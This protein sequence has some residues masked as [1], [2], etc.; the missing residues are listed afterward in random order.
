M[1][2]SGKKA[3]IRLLMCSVRERLHLSC[4]AEESCAVSKLARDAGLDEVTVDNILEFIDNK[5]EKENNYSFLTEESA[6]LAE[7]LTREE[8]RRRRAEIKRRLL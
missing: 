2:L 4:S 8:R 7:H 3:H 1:I 5:R 6:D